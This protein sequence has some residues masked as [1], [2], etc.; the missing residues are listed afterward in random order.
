MD[1]R[2]VFFSQTGNTRKVTEAITNT[3]GAGGH[4]VNAISLKDADPDIV[5]TANLIG[6]GT[7]CFSSQA[8]Q[9][10]MNFINTLPPMQDKKAFIFATCGG[11]PGRVLLDMKNGL[12]QKG[13][14]VISGAIFR[15]EVHHPA[16]TLIG[17]F[18]GRPNAE[19]LDQARD[20][21]KALCT[22]ISDH[23]AA[24][25]HHRFATSRNHWGFYELLGTALFDTYLRFFMPKPK[26]VQQNCDQCELCAQ[27]CPN[28]NISLKPYPVLGGNCI[29]C[30]R[31][32]NTCPSKAFNAN[33]HLSN[34]I[35]WLLYNPTFIRWFGDLAPDE[36]IYQG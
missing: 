31:C 17:R 9:P 15:G 26:L 12:R 24:T 7:P 35:L 10:V 29:R 5:N 21:A 33:W 27:E 3:F 36:R 23:N 4:S 8:P 28:Q 13:A 19:D 6:L 11:A 32:H 14:N 1:V 2:V 22:Q 30:Y 18:P 20:F 25:S 16:P 34:P